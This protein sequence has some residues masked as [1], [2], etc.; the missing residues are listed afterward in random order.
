MLHSK[1]TMLLSLFI[2]LFIYSQIQVTNVHLKYVIVRIQRRFDCKTPGQNISQL[3]VTITFK[4]H[5]AIIFIYL[6][7]YLF[8]NTSD[9][10]ASKVCNCTYTK[11]F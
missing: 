5:H 6:F 11:T 1:H 2:C 3:H 7:I 4:T 8:T 10:C 9:K